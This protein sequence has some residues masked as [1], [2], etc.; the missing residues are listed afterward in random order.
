MKKVLGLDLG[1][2]SIGWALIETNDD[3]TLNCI[4]ASDSRIIPYN[5]DQ[6]KC[7]NDFSAG[8]STSFNHDRTVKRIMRRRYDRY[9][10]RR[11]LLTEQLRNHGMLPDERLAK[12]PLLDL[13]VLRAKAATLGQQLTLPEIGRVLYHLNQ[14]RGYRHTKND[15]AEKNQRQ[16][17]Q[18][19]NRR[20]TVIQE[21]NQTIGQHFAEKIKESE[22]QSP[23]GVFY[24]YRVKNQVFPRRAYQE[25]FDRIM[26]CQ[27]Q[28]YPDILTDDFIN[29][30]RDYIIYYQRDLKSCKHL[31]SL[32]EFEKRTY[33]NAKGKDVENGPR[34]APKSSPLFQV[35]KIWQEINNIKLRN[36][37]GEE[38][39][40]TQE[41][42]NAMFDHLNNHGVLKVSEIYKI[43]D[44]KKNEGWWGGKNIGRGLS[45]NTTKLRIREALNGLP[46]QDDLLKFN[47]SSI[48]SK[49]CCEET[50]EV[51]R[52]IPASVVEQ[53]LY[54]LWH[55]L[56][57]ID[58]PE[59]LKKNLKEKFNIL[60]E[61]VLERLVN[62]DFRKDGYGNMSCK[63]MRRILPY[64]QQG[65]LYSDACEYIGVN[66][67]NSITMAE[68]AKRELLTILPQIKKGELRQPVVE[69]ILNQMINIVNA[70]IK[71]YGSIDEIRIELARELKQSKD[72]REE[73]YKANTQNNT[74]NNR[75]AK[76]IQEYNI[77]PTI[78]RIKR[79]KMWEESNHQCIYC[80]KP[81]NATDFLN[82][83]ESEREHILPKA[84][85]FDNS[86][87]N[88]VC[89]CQQCN[90][91][92][93]NRTAYDYMHSKSDTE[94]NNYLKRIGDLHE[95][96]TIS[97]TKYEKL[98]A[99][100]EDYLKRKAKCEE[101]DVDKKLW[102][103]F[104]E[105]QLR[106]SQHIAK[107]ASTI[108]KQ[109]CR[110][111]YSTSGSITDYLRHLW[112]Y[113]TILHNLNFK[114]YKKAGLTEIVTIQ[115]GDDTHQEERIINWSKRLDHRHHAIDA[116]VIACT[117]Q[118]I[119]QRI[120]TLNAQRETMSQEVAKQKQKWDEKKSL[121]DKW[122]SI[123]PHFSV[124]TVSQ[125]VS[126]MFV[127][128]K[129]GKKAI[130]PGKRYTYHGGHKH[131]EQ[132][133]ILIP[134]GPL[135]ENTF[136]GKIHIYKKG[137]VEEQ[138]IVT[139]YKVGVGIGFL[140]SGKEEY[141]VKMVKDKKTGEI[142]QEITDGIKTILD[143]II[144]QAVRQAIEKRLNEGFPT[145]R[146]YRD[147]PDGYKKALNNIRT[148]E[149]HP[150]FLDEQQALSIRSV[151]CATGLTAVVPIKYDESN[152]P[153]AFVKPGNNHHI[154]IY[155]DRDGNLIEH[156][157]TFLHAVDRQK[158]SIPIIIED[159]SS[160]WDKC[161][162][163]DFPQSFLQELPPDGMKLQLSLQRNEMFV[164]GMTDDEYSDA[165]ASHDYVAISE[166]LYRIQ[167]ISKSDYWL[168]L[169]TETQNDK[170]TE[171][172]LANKYI[173][174]QSLGA[175]YSLHPH[176]VRIS[177]L[178]ELHEHK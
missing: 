33:K 13:W 59:Q 10:L 6:N 164:I 129:A 113:D 79:Y 65:M 28:Y 24:T 136:Y 22:V 99:S 159:T 143:S 130:S 45:P 63:F 14:R 126:T 74:N 157:V 18:D 57:S 48:N 5:D 158:Y 172:K 117:R 38:L 95:K 131:L 1:V 146:T 165:I 88:T 42:R 133:H 94:F 98:L 62:I 139:R 122:L 53:P 21:R 177:I 26:D 155:C 151:R 30:L 162:Q 2:A 101:T 25:E 46:N 32:C 86:F 8:K 7:A 29:H 141:K 17:V 170:T 67:S 47:L 35:C 105:R 78:N 31:V 90:R 135:H 9:Q 40:I 64:L 84:L 154:A 81:V 15:Q 124:D 175:F 167:S 168:R 169:H 66:H 11:T 144:D 72:E 60:D 43:L 54:M 160:V 118:S 4:I 93:S 111:V 161:N 89:S 75:I 152:N 107:Y 134:R 85:L 153:I 92:K 128:F 171:G 44:I 112:G 68:N 114:R 156:A 125:T 174:V 70:L 178:G 16:Y 142:K 102:E 104:I 97:N 73:S 110:N 39:F 87:S 115:N 50:G 173:R 51:I 49:Q 41:Q 116:I 23:K 20:F 76:R 145:G 37:K 121:L 71:K 163:N 12:L 82:S 138:Q 83:I 58:E 77:T 120:N 27:R 108:L 19:V 91:E 176:K 149:Q 109:V 140:F 100:Y 137:G 103:D 34:V 147:E 148:V 61:E 150:I 69:K 36:K 119:I 127:S 3:G 166:H 132:N 52:I 56:Y 55:T 96:K 106:E 80:G 123:Q